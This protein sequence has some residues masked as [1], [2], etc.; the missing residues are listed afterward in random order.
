ME[1]FSEIMNW[2]NV[3]EQ[4]EIFQNNTPCKFGFI[5]ELFQRDFYEKLYESYPKID[6][7]GTSSKIGKMSYGKYFGKYGR[8]KDGTMST[9]GDEND[10]NLSSEWNKLKRYAQS[11]EFIENFRKF[12]GVPVNRLKYFHFIAMKKGGFQFPHVHNVGPSTLI[13]MLYFSKNWKDGDPGGTYIATEED[14]SSIIFEPYNLD[15][16]V[17]IFHD[18]PKAMH[19]ARYIKKDVER[20]ALQI[21]LEQYG[22]KTGWS[23]E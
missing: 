23:G 17:A 6:D 9:I 2:N 14:E 7:M 20:C 19:G 3:F 8:N 10:P 1:D 22:E 18:G 12:S 21:T 11:Q 13:F 5:E 4:S 16:S 15:N